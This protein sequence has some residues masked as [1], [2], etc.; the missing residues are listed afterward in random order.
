[1][2]KVN[3]Q[4]A[5]VFSKEPNDSIPEFPSRIDPT[6]PNLFIT[7]AMVQ[8]KLAQLDFNKATGTSGTIK[9]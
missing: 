8:K 9:T 4:F 1:M 5:S 3:D 2:T 7:P 6:I